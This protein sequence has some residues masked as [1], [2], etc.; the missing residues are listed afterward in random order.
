MAGESDPEDS[1]R[2]TC[3]FIEAEQVV[4]IN[5]YVTATLVCHPSR[6]DMD[7]FIRAST[8]IAPPYSSC[9]LCRQLHLE[10]GAERIR[11]EAPEILVG[12]REPL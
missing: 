7:E 2:A 3:S 12:V 11:A 1:K 5:A 10:H 4:S 8:V 9:R 6:T